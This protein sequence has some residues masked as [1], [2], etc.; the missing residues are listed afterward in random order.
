MRHSC[1][2]LILAASASLPFVCGAA[3]SGDDHFQQRVWPLLDRAC[4]KCHGVEKQKGGLRLDSREAALKGGDTG[5]AVV[6]GK[7][8]ESLLLTLIRHADPERDRMP[9]KE[10]LHEAEIADVERWIT[11]GAPWPQRVATAPDVT[12]PGERLGDAWSDKRNPIVRIFGGRR[13]ELWSLK[14]IS[15]PQPP[16][17]S[18]SEWPR[19]PL[20]RFVLAKLEAT[21]Q[22]PSPE[23]TR[24]TLVRRLY[25]DLTGLPPLPE[26]VTAFLND[27]APDAYER[28]VDKLLASPRYGEHWARMWLDVVRYS[29]SNGFDWDEFRATAWRFRDYVI[30]SFNT[31]KPFNRFVRE[32]LAGDE[33]VSGAP[34]DLAE[35][36]CLVGT[37]F[38]RMGPH[39]NSAALFGEEKKVSEQ[40][41][42]DLVETTGAAF[43][44]MTLSCCRCH[45]HKYDPLSQADHYR[46]RAFFEGVKLRDDFPIDLASE[47]DTI[48]K[49][50]EMIDAQIAEKRKLIDE[51]LK[52]AKEQLRAERIAK[53]TE[54]E[55]LL[56]R[57]EAAQLDEGAKK[58]LEKLKKKV[59]PSDDDAKARLSEE[60]K[61]RVEEANA[62]VQA[63]KK[64]R[65]EFTKAMLAMDDDSAAPPPTH[66]L[67]GGDLKQPRQL[68]EPGFL[69]ALDPNPAE[70]R[71]PLRKKS[72]GRRT[73]LAEWIVSQQN[74][75]TTRVLVN[76]VWQGYFGEGIVAT[77]N[78][79]GLAGAKPSNPELLD[80]LAKEF[81]RGGWSLKKLH[82]LIVTSATYRQ[83][84]PATGTDRAGLVRQGPRRLTAEA[85]RDSMLAVSGRLTFIDGGAP[86]WPTLPGEVLRAN[87][88]VLDDNA[89]K[90]KGWYPS[91][92]EKMG[93][94]SVFMVQK[95]TLRVPMME[96][97][98]LP[99]NAVSC[100]RRN[101]STV[102]PQ[103]LT[104]LNSPFA[105]EMARSF[106]E[107]VQR[108]AGDDVGAQITRAFA[109]AL[110]RPPDNDELQACTR[111]REQRS[112]PELCR[113]LMN[114]N[115]FIYID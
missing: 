44:G 30:R 109:L 88:A 16:A 106:A 91:P 1:L 65:R 74:P 27:N 18:R 57:T 105:V 72:T 113:A 47:Q 84:L 101:V 2:A 99:E 83:G 28:L 112:L 55:Q 96:T 67:E 63:L 31:D 46:L 108:E 79:F 17:V 11:E 40:L 29:D 97:F 78:D 37:G 81:V 25:F 24:Q 3:P 66:I 86:I 15:D 48:R 69:S 85:L 52:P 93:A 45:D 33:M 8:Q 68:V 76:R 92:P 62:P 56:L 38:L 13:L 50:H 95:R 107:R 21:G 41:M 43:L 7:P 4:V 54:E 9:P 61:K 12:V 114:S 35:Q 42:A 111:F 39:D 94:R 26:E 100:A 36:D 34:R 82:R 23:A 90:T 75:L 53:L 103:A 80:W 102:A 87:P 58:R 32:Q 60:E 110:Q 115:E 6:P 71:P 51:V 22:Q 20:D 104:L 89:E 19:N 14:P 77:A 5:P 49:Q 70:I 10:K 73:A 59:E 98:D 64:E